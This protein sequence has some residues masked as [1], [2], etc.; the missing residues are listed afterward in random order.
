MAFRRALLTAPLL[1]ALAGWAGSRSGPSPEA[2]CGG[3]H[4][5]HFVERGT[6]ATCHRGD[7]LALRK[8]IAHHRLLRGRA[9]EQG[10]ADAPAVAEG[11]GRVEQLACRRCHV[12]DGTGNRLA[13]ELDRIAWK[14][15][16]RELAR[17]LAVPAEN[18]PRFGLDDRQ[19]ESVIAFLLQNADTVHAAATYRVR[20]SDAGAKGDST[21]ER[22][23]GGCHRALAADGPLGR[24]SAGPNLS[25]VFSAFY[26]A[27]AP[28]SRSWTGESLGKWLENP[29]SV[30]PRS[31]MRPVRLEPGELE[32]LVEELEAPA[33]RATTPREEAA[34]G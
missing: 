31:A 15:E 5:R 9:A 34:G 8:E 25:G 22:R 1:L 29:R 16:Q 33:S 11:R 2:S 14:R 17:S 13:T 27:T 6:C 30:R 21:F 10:L 19:V 7:P 12:L 3:C 26:P 23:C 28:E 20:F 18:M 24:G 4:A 32:R